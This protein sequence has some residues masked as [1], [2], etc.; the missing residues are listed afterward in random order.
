MNEIL[1]TVGAYE[2]LFCAIQSNIEVGDEAIII[3]PF[4][5]C[6]EPLIRIA[7][8]IPRLIPLRNVSIKYKLFTV[9]Y[10]LTIIIF[11]DKAGCSS[12]SFQ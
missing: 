9:N 5:D 11:K 1:V 6:Y 8:G 4:F 3:E 7:G 10:I 12:F 2:A